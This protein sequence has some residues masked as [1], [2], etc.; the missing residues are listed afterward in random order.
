MPLFL[1]AFAPYLVV[2]NIKKND[3]TKY[4]VKTQ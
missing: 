3:Y 1:C 2:Y 4:S